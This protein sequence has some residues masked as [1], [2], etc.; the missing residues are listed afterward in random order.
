MPPPVRFA[1]GWS[2]PGETA[3]R[4]MFVEVESREMWRE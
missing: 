2:I 3:N 4:G 1:A